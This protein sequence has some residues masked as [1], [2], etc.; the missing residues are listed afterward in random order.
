V[1]A[2]TATTGIRRRTYD[3][4]APRSNVAAADKAARDKTARDKTVRGRSAYSFRPRHPVVVADDRAAL[5]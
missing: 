5:A 1:A 3:I 2:D 4:A